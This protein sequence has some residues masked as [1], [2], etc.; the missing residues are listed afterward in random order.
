M[1]DV[2]GAVFRTAGSK[3]V[4][5]GCRHARTPQGDG[6]RWAVRKGEEGLYVCK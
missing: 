4:G 2:G 3:A 1:R 6:R 5:V